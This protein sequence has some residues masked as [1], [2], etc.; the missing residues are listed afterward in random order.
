MMRPRRA[1]VINALS[2]LVWA[3]T[4]SAECAWVM[5]KQTVNIGVAAAPPGRHDMAQFLI[6][7]AQAAHENKKTCE[8]ALSAEQRRLRE[9]GNRPRMVCLPDTVD[10]RGPKGK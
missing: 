7:E 8:H 6:W 2:L 9:A 1:S 5:W 10:P 4:D 3:A